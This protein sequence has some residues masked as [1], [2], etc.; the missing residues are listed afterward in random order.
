M[1]MTIKDLCNEH[2]KCDSCPFRLVCPNYG[3]SW[4]IVPGDFNNDDNK[5]VTRAIIETAR[6]LEQDHRIA[7]IKSDIDKL[8]R[9]QLTDKTQTIS[10][11][12]VDRVFNLHLYGSRDA[13]GKRDS[14]D[15][16][17]E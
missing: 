4:D 2:P 3:G 12:A 16:R 7:D 1:K 9:Y 11:K 14:N 15:C 17:S 6:R 8:T 13:N 10:K 5:A